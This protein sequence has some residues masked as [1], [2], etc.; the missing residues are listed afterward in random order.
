MTGK[1]HKEYPR[2]PPDYVMYVLSIVYCISVLVRV[3]SPLCWYM[4]VYARVFPCVYF[5]QF[6]GWLKEH[7]VLLWSPFTA[8]W[9]WGW[10]E[11]CTGVNLFLGRP[12]QSCISPNIWKIKPNTP[13]MFAQCSLLSG[14]RDATLTFRDKKQEVVSFERAESKVL[15][16]LS[17]EMVR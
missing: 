15:Q 16:A 11:G 10:W 7:V 2:A 4:H 1:L 8:T 3:G 5:F 9:A 13:W 14:I 17:V 6:D 12:Q